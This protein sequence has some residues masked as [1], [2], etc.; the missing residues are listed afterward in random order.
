MCSDFLSSELVQGYLTEK[1][2][3][4]EEQAVLA[5]GFSSLAGSYSSTTNST[6]V[7]MVRN[8]EQPSIEKLILPAPLP[9]ELPWITDQERV[10][11]ASLSSIT[12]ASR[13]TQ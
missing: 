13:A 9:L 3:E 7:A 2:M 6:I 5:G 12:G 8:A 1:Y 11:K 10:S 4:P